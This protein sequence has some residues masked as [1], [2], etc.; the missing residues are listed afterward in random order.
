MSH[1]CTLTTVGW[2]WLV[3]LIQSGTLVKIGAE[4]KKLALLVTGPHKQEKLGFC[5]F[6]SSSLLKQSM[7]SILQRER[8][9]EQIKIDSRL[10][11]IQCH[12][13]SV[14]SGPIYRKHV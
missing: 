5:G 12:I 3:H 6:A 10:L 9:K 11:L 8:T 13:P 2:S 1:A 4:R 7:K 14:W